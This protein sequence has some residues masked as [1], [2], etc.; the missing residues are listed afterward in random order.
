[1]LIKNI[2]LSKWGNSQGIRIGNDILNELDIENNDIEFEAKVKNNQV[3]LTPK[4]KLPQTLEEVFADYE[5]EPLGEDDK[6]DWGESVGREL[7]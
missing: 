6:Y 3:I 1:M 2:K 4:K 5:G 7:L